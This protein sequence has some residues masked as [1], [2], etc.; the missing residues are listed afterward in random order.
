MEFQ[1]SLGTCTYRKNS[2]LAIK[3]FKI[4]LNSTTFLLSKEQVI[5]SLPKSINTLTLLSSAVAGIIGSG[6]LLSPLACVKIAG[7]AAIIA[8]GLGG[9]LMMIVA[10]TFVILTR[11]IPITGGTVR[12]FQLTHGHFA[13]FGF[14]WIAWLAWVA[15][16]PIEMLAIIQYS[17][18]YLPNLMTHDPTPVL[19]GKG[20]CVA[21]AGIA[22]ITLINSLGMKIYERMNYLILAIKLI[23]PI[24]AIFLLFYSHFD[25]TNFTSQGFM[26][27][28]I[29][30]IFA[31]LPLA[32][33]IYSFIGF[34]PVVQLAAE[35][36]NPKQAI[37]TAIFGALF[38]C[39]I[40]YIGVQIAFIGALPKET[41][42]HGWSLIAFAGDKGPIAGLLTLFGLLFFVK[43]LYFDAG[44]SPF[45]TALVQSMATSRIT[46][47][48]CQNAYFPQFLMKTNKHHIPISAILFNSLI[49][50]L[51]FLPFPSWQ[52]MV[53]FLVSCLVLGYVVGPLSLMV[54][55]REKPALFPF[56]QKLIH[57][58]CLVAFYICNLLIYWSGWNIV[59]KI[60]ILFFIG[61][62][63]L[64]FNLYKKGNTAFKKT[65]HFSRGSWSL[66]YLLGISL[67]SYLGSFGGI[68][69]IS[70]GMDF[71]YLGILSLSVYMT[72][73]FT[74]LKTRN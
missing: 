29:K 37:P 1:Y 52:H 51:F 43:L 3:S 63:V 38:I 8:W 16:A 5:M 60:M 74:T 61:Y 41:F 44:L 7:P 35:S 33:V 59:Y 6:W 67:I 15:V 9:I 70:F 21:F 39:M 25:S 10:S 62:I 55:V 11:T 40:I 64:I 19:T 23:I 31:A 22:I 32:G 47:A 24:T 14:S 53:G 27:Y 46:Y 42:I 57:P 66:V 48:M 45:G 36:K 28:G 30:S 18:N 17:A 56:S 68:H 65:F 73:Y 4:P 50:L 72:A 12:F 2:V 20:F 71:I 13:G 49:G 34:N 69:K 58:L 54:L 26:P